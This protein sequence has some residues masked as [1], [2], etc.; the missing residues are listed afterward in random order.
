MSNTRKVRR[1]MCKEK[2]LLM[3]RLTAF[4]GGLVSLEALARSRTIFPLASRPG[5][6]R[7][8]AYYAVDSIDLTDEAEKKGAAVRVQVAENCELRGNPTKSDRGRRR[9]RF[10]SRM[11]SGRI[12]R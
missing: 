12:S 9:R 2:C 6:T 10:A 11:T 7:Q 8:Q 3:A 1:S 4:G 5:K